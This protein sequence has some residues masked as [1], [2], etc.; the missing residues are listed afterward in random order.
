MEAQARP[1]RPRTR[2]PEE[3]K[4]ARALYLKNYYLANAER[5][6]QNSRRSYQRKTQAAA[7]VE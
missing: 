6:K 5:M 1:G 7:A 2:T 3:I 4:I